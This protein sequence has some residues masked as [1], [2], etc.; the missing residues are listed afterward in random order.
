MKRSCLQRYTISRIFGWLQVVLGVLVVVVSVTSLLRFYHAGLLNLHDDEICSHFQRE[1]TSLEFSSRLQDIYLKVQDLQG[2]VENAV[3][4]MET[5]AEPKDPKLFKSEYDKYKKFLRDDVKGPLDTVK[6]SLRQIRPSAVQGVSESSVDHQ[7]QQEVEGDPLEHFFL[8][9]ELRKYLH[10]KENRLGKLNILGANG[11]YTTIGHACVLM[12]KELEI[13]MNYDIGGYCKDDWNL[14]QKLMIQGCDPLPRRRCLARAP[15]L[16][17]KPLPINE[18]LWKVPDNRNVRWD[19]YQCR[20]FACL[21]SNRTNKGFFKCSGC[22]NLAKSEAPKWVRNTTSNADFLIAEVLSIKP[23][24]IRIGLDFSVGVG[25]F[26]AR[27]REHNVTIVS[28]AVNLGAPFCEMIALRG[29]VPLY[30]TIN[31]RLPFFDNTLDLIHTGGLLDAWIDLQLL[32]F[33]VFDWDRVL[34]PGGFL[35]LDKFFCTR[36][37]LDDY[38]YMFLQ[39]R[40]K[41]HK[42]VVSPKSYTEV[43]FSALLEKPPRP[44]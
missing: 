6:L 20:D 42:W 18:S 34:R 15:R 22:F 4:E 27:M 10:V 9:E 41:K 13:Y 2:K 38:L 36:R 33:I 40:Y 29:L 35:W 24:E 21:M 14:G 11:T 37:D 25:T 17:Q 1:P 30:V 43:Y 31:Q 12:K 44:F 32:D 7:Q 5:N 3:K 8:N 28:A 23:G 19:N 39:L 16:F 26:A